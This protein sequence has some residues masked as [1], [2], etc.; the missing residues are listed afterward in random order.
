MGLYDN[1]RQNRIDSILPEFV[2]WIHSVCSSIKYFDFCECWANGRMYARRGKSKDE[3][4]HFLNL[5]IYYQMK[6]FSTVLKDDIK[7][8]H[9]LLTDS[10]V[11]KTKRSALYDELPERY[12]AYILPKLYLALHEIHEDHL[13]PERFKK[14]LEPAIQKDEDLYS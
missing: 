6:R 10:G 14:S 9:F 8:I 3:D 11:V 1:I 13:H 4:E 7:H 2:D 5:A 12:L